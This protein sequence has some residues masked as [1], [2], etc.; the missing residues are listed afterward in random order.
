MD[1]DTRESLTAFLVAEFPSFYEFM[2]YARV[3]RP[4][5]EMAGKDP[6]RV[7][8]LE[9]LREKE[10]IRTEAL[11]ERKAI[12]DAGKLK[13]TENRRFSDL[14]GSPLTD[15]QVELRAKGGQ[16]VR[17]KTTGKTMKFVPSTVPGMKGHGMWTEQN[18]A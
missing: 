3:I 7:A 16:L 15:R 6:A 13:G 12:R 1:D 2:A 14:D 9:K 10:R 5:F 8:S 18:P 4:R 17:E 11:R